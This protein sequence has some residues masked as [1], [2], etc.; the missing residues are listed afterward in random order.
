[1]KIIV[2]LV[3]SFVILVQLKI[4]VIQGAVIKLRILQ[5]LFVHSPILALSSECVRLHHVIVEVDWHSKFSTT[6]FL[7]L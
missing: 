3:D 2:V 7:I 5:I 1:M 6:R 4:I